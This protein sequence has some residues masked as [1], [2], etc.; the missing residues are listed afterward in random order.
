MAKR[1]V[2]IDGDIVSV[3]SVVSIIPKFV[4]GVLVREITYGKGHQMRKTIVDYDKGYE[5]EKKVRKG[6]YRL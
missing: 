6:M 3:E 4:D 2:K 1:E 5:I